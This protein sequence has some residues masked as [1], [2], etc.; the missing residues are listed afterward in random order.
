MLKTVFSERYEKALAEARDHHLESKTYSGKLMRPHVPFI[1][2][3][4]DGLKCESILD[5]GCGKG[6]QYDWIMPEGTTVEQYFGCGVT[7][8]DPAVSK[9]SSDPEPAVFDLV[10]CTH[11]LGSIPIEDRPGVVDRIA[12]LATKA[13]YIAEKIG[14]VGKDIYTDKHQFEYWSRDDWE[15][16]LKPLLPLEVTLSTRHAT[17]RGIQTIRKVLK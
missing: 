5:Y 10:I 1:K 8:Y 2:R 13:V 11:T 7:K 16:L 6:S 15:K 4:I 14:P 9:F 17:S 3:I 12:S